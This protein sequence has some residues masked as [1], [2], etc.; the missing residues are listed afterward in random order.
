MDVGGGIAG[1][2]GGG[3]QGAAAGAFVSS[4]AESVWQFGNWLYCAYHQ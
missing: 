2:F 3:P 1:F 4:G